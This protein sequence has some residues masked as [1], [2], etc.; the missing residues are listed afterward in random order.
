L[1]DTVHTWYV[2][3]YSRRRTPRLRSPCSA[4]KNQKNEEV[5]HLS[6]L[7]HVLEGLFEVRLVRQAE[8]MGAVDGQVDVL[9]V[10]IK[11]RRPSERRLQGFHV[12][13][14]GWNRPVVMRLT[15][16][17][18]C[19]VLSS[20]FSREPKSRQRRS[21]GRAAAKPLPLSALALVLVYS[22]VSPDPPG[23][24]PLNLHQ[25]EPGFLL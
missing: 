7:D 9:R 22:R 1:F 10:P 25:I 21:A 13:L 17:F 24:N 12:R 11:T 6:S 3:R 18:A 16:Q 20:P 14:R 19:G 5:D 2:V 15:S 8:W 23:T 4:R